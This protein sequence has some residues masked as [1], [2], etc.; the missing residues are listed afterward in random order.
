MNRRNEQLNIRAVLSALAFALVAGCVAVV[1]AG[2]A[3]DQVVLKS[4]AIHHGEL[5]EA[6][7][8]QYWLQLSDGTL[9][10]FP[11]ADVERVVKASE[12]GTTPE[13][14]PQDLAPSPLSAAEQRTAAHPE[15]KQAAAEPTSEAK[16][17]RDER[18]VGGGFDV[19]LVTAGRLRFRLNNP[20]IANIDLRAGAAGGVIASSSAVPFPLVFIGPEVSFIKNSRVHPTLALQV[21]AGVYSSSVYPWVGGGAGIKIDLTR[22]VE[23]NASAAVGVLGSSYVGVVPDVGVSFVW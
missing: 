8:G 17:P 7:D 15:P 3:R 1:I 16:P 12:V 9:Q 23:L 18:T 22:V 11:F 14:P 19:G 10:A 4:G 5:L 13:P 2:D 20:V 21:G 6:R